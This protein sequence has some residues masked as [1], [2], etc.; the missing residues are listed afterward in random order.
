MVWM[1]DMFIF[2]FKMIYNQYTID[3][4]DIVLV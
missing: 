2:E 3:Q 4:L 1:T